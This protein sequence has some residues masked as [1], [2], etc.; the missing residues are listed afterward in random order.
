MTS[1]LEHMKPS[2]LGAAALL[3][4][5][6]CGGG[7]RVEGMELTLGITTARARPALEAGGPRTLLNA[8]GTRASFTRALVTLGSVELLP[9][10]EAGWLRLLRG[11]SPVSTAWAHSSSSPRRLG[12]PHVLGLDGA[13]GDVTE[14]GVLRPPPG[15]YCRARLTFEP[16][17]S[18]AQGLASA[19]AG[20]EPVDMEGR[21]L[22]VRGTLSPT[23]GGV[24]QAFDATS[25]GHSSVD[26]VLDGLTLSEEQ[27]RATLVV[28]L[29]WD[30]WLD[31]VGPQEPPARVDLLGNVARSASARPAAAP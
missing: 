7:D 1:E 14:L 21:S 3:C 19:T 29:A 16:A 6:A 12:T 31:G 2:V 28:T 8:Q 26:V 27:P 10:E 20:P 25:A 4:L 18:D 17:D 5:A 22:H 13:D 30:T 23:D 11:L 9:C 15:R 24:A